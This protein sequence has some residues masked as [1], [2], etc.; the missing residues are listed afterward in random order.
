MIFSTDVACLQG[1][2]NNKK[3]LSKNILELFNSFSFLRRISAVPS[4]MIE[5]TFSTDTE[6]KNLVSACLDE[7]LLLIV[8]SFLIRHPS[9]ELPSGHGRLTY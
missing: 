6:K 4:H 5:L 9:N 7:E 8:G 2:N 3:A 1:F